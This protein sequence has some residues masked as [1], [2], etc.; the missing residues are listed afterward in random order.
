MEF[1]FF[2]HLELKWAS[3]LGVCRIHYIT[4][5][6]L[7][8]FMNTRMSSMYLTPVLILMPFSSSF[9]SHLVS[10]VF[11]TTLVIAQGHLLCLVAQE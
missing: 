2:T 4:E 3:D 6:H 7:S 1:E 9:S 10:L 5:I 11:I 8:L